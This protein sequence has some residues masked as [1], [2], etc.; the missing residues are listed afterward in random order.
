MISTVYSGA[1][2]LASTVAR[3]GVWPA[4]THL[5]H[6]LFIS[7]NLDMSASQILAVMSLALLVPASFSRR[8][9]LA[10]M[11]RV[12]SATGLPLAPLATTPAR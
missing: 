6:S 2:S 5:S 9:M 10:R 7:A 11:S 3:A 1:A 8:S 4:D 12:C